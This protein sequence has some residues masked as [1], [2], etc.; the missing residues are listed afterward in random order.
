MFYVV[1]V[2]PSAYE[3]YQC[4]DIRATRD[5]HCCARRSGLG[6]YQYLTGAVCVN[7]CIN[8]QYGVILCSEW[9]HNGEVVSA[10]L[11]HWRNCPVATAAFFWDRRPRR[12]C[13]GSSVWR[14]HS[15]L[16]FK[17]QS[18]LTFRPLK[19]SPLGCFDRGLLVAS[20]GHFS[21]RSPC[22]SGL[23]EVPFPKHFCWQNGT[24]VLY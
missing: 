1:R 24:K 11:F 23:P 21:G 16:I 7:E 18:A 5:M 15:G 10:H 20:R 14:R 22:H 9:A 2:S 19:I 13:I 17:S 6:S 4:S 8:G 12:F 3:R